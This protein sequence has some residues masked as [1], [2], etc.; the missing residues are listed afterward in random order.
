MD[1][2]PLC[3]N[4]IITFGI[5]C[6]VVGIGNPSFVDRGRN[7]FSV[8]SIYLVACYKAHFPPE[9]FQRNIKFMQFP[10]FKVLSIEGFICTFLPC[11][12]PGLELSGIIRRILRDTLHIGNHPFGHMVNAA[13]VAFAWFEQIV[14]MH[15]DCQHQK[16]KEYKKRAFLHSISVT[17]V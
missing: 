8:D 4:G 10:R 11:F 17:L 1:I 7:L 2:R 3:S 13:G 16:R 5:F 12:R 6:L 15:I 14:C 9:I